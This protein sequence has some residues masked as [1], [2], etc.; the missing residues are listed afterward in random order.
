MNA[1]LYSC[2]TPYS[3]EDYSQMGS[4]HSSGC[5]KIGPNVIGGFTVADRD[6]MRDYR[7]CVCEGGWYKSVVLPIPRGPEWDAIA[8][9]PEF[10]KILDEGA[11]IICSTMTIN[12]CG[13][14]R[15]DEYLV[16]EKLISEC[17]V[18]KM[19]KYLSDN[20]TGL[21]VSLL[22]LTYWLSA[23]EDSHYEHELCLQFERIYAV[24]AND[25]QVMI[26]IAAVG[27]YN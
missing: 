21:I 8:C 16:Q 14:N 9:N 5:S 27:L 23:G 4:D 12:S 1:Q 15:I 17:W 2:T 20:T 11:E 26:P 24:Y 25:I 22:F 19:N 3:S 10:N 6:F 13:C 18:H 7:F